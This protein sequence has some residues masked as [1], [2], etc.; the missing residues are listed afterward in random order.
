MVESAKSGFPFC[1]THIGK[2]G[3]TYTLIASS[4]ADRKQWIDR[5]QDQRARRIMERQHVFDIITISDSTFG[6]VC[7]TNCSTHYV[8][9]QN[10][11][12]IVIG[13]DDG[14]YVGI[15]GD[16][17]SFTK[18]LNLEKIRHIEILED[19]KM[20][21]VLQDKLLLSYSIALLDDPKKLSNRNGQKLASNVTYFCAGALND[22]KYVAVLKL[23]G[24]K[25]S[26]KI[27][28]PI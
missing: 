9:P 12:K 15:E 7:R 4:P 27:L 23:K 17:T 18:V 13:A 5:I 24:L 1:F 8:T 16:S 3:S 6:L 28:E 19:Y 2:R 26:C 21:L 10:S 20:M 11:R 22:R 14:V 25:S